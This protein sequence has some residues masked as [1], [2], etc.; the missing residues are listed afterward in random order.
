MMSKEQKREYADYLKKASKEFIDMIDNDT[1]DCVK[2]LKLIY[3]YARAGFFENRA[4]K[5]G[6]R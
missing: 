3:G 5:V 2:I 4:G 6:V 1:E